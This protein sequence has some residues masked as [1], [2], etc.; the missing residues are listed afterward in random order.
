[1]TLLFSL[2]LAA[3]D[4]YALYEAANHVVELDPAH[5]MVV[6]TE[7]KMGGQPI[8]LPLT[9]VTNSEGENLNRMDFPNGMFVVTG[10]VDGEA[11]D[12]SD[13]NGVSLKSKE[14][15]DNRQRSGRL[16]VDPSLIREQYPGATVVGKTKIGKLKVWEV[17]YP[18]QGYPDITIF[19][20]KKT[21]YMV[22]RESQTLMEG[23]LVPTK[24]VFSE[25]M[26]T[27]LGVLYGKNET[28]MG[29]ILMTSTTLSV[30]IEP[31][32]SADLSLPEPV[33]RAVAERDAQTPTEAP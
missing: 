10:V 25:V 15:A 22:A 8:T 7:M 4:P 16:G 29:P 12:Y 2:A 17:N 20:D 14:E 21:G 27:D 26:T 31:A 23:A 11:F 13:I 30:T 24:E 3:P 6:K 18:G 32:D 19:F 9:V 33:A 5:V 1:V 28:S